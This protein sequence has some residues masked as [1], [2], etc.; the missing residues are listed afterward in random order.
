MVEDQDPLPARRRARKLSTFPRPPDTP[1]LTTA[2]AAPT[3]Q[4]TVFRSAVSHELPPIQDRSHPICPNDLALT[5]PPV[6]PPCGMVP[7]SP[8]AARRPPGYPKVPRKFTRPR[9]R[10]KPLVPTGSLLMLRHHSSRLPE[11]LRRS[12]Q[13]DQTRIHRRSTRRSVSRKP[14]LPRAPQPKPRAL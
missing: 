13:L 1:P 4:A 10:R 7:R 11:P 2:E 14:K 3:D 9:T 12:T 8:S 6:P 5:S